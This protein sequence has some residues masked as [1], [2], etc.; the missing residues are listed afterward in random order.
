MW[1]NTTFYL[2]KR[3]HTDIRKNKE[4]VTLEL[5]YFLR[6]QEII[7]KTSTPYIY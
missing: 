1:S 6:D 3:L 5:Q 7:Y 4:C 2:V